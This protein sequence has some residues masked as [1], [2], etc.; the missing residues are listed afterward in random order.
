MISEFRDYWARRN[1]ES[2]NGAPDHE[3]DSE[4]S[5]TTVGFNV[6]V[7]LTHTDL[8]PRN[9]YILVKV[10]VIVGILDWE[11][12]LV[13]KLLG[14]HFCLQKSMFSSHGLMCFVLAL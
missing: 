6:Q 7:I 10:G 2:N 9:M 12:L 5:D 3:L 14:V 13:S 4:I 8:A 11:I 1:P